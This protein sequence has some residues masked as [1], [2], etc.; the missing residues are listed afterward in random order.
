MIE[1]L[2]RRLFPFINYVVRYPIRILI[3]CVITAVIGFLL[4]INLKI[5]NDLSKLIPQ[6]YPSVQA[7]NTLREQVGAE[8][9]LAVAIESPSFEVNKKFAEML[10]SKTMALKNPE[11]ADNFF[12][13]A[14]FRRETSFL[15]NNALYF[16]TE[17]EL[18]LLEE[19]LINR[20]DEARLEANPFYFELEEKETK[21]DSLHE[22][23]EDMYD[24][25]IG[26][27]YLV[28]EDSLTL[29]IKFYPA[30]SQTDIEFIRS[31][32]STMQHL[33]DEMNPASFH[34][35][36]EVTLAGR[37]L[38][39][40][41]EVE[42]ITKDVK[43]S[44]GIGVL[45]VL[46]VAVLYFLYKSSHLSKGAE[47]SFRKL[48]HELIRTPSIVI[49]MAL[50]LVLSLC[51]TFGIVFL[52]FENLNI[53]TSTLGLVLFGMGID[54]G[55]HFFA[56][57]NEERETEGSITKA[58]ITTF[59]TSGQAIA[60]VGITTSAA[61]FVLSI[62]DFKGFSEFGI[63]A[64][65][66]IIFSIIAYVVFL[67]ALLSILEQFHLL[68]LKFAAASKPERLKITR[69]RRLANAA[70]PLIL[71]VSISLTVYSVIKI[72]ETS[73]NYNF[74]EL[75]PEFVRYQ[76]VS[77]KVDQAYSDKGTRNS[78]YIITDTPEDAEKVAA[79]LHQRIENDEVSPTVGSIEIFQDR[80]PLTKEASENKLSR[81]SDIREK[82]NDPFLQGQDNQ[83]LQR[84]KRAASTTMP[85]SLNEVP[86]FIRNPFTSKNGEIGTLV[87]IHPSVG[88][89]DGRNSINFSDDVGQ[90]ALGNGKIYYA[91]STSIVASDMLRLMINEVPLM[92]LLT[93]IIII[94]LKFLFLRG[95][96][97]TLLALL[98]LATSFIWLFGL[99]HSFGLQL[100]F[101]NLVVLPTILGIGDDS[102]IHIT[103]RYVEEGK[104]RISSVL[105][106]TGE[107]V[108]ISALTTM[109]GFG[110][111]LFSIHPGM[112]SIGKLAILG[113]L[114]TLIAALILLPAVL[115]ILEI[116]EDFTKPKSAIVSLQK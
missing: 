8:N 85:I 35:E 57:Y 24:E 86:D 72:P 51:W 90:V 34:P 12:T 29:A 87:I 112:V 15:E 55:I 44:F 101:Y 79:V 36:M 50:P 28:S 49:V 95:L 65:M 75:E 64:G 60:V 78:A 58:L 105:R 54:F 69:T 88:L 47:F 111:L 22:D 2:F 13:R 37:L 80:F 68:N 59:M 91:G 38:R 20:I 7:L 66:G 4:A 56:R 61:F 43:D 104:G 98:P 26:S 73:F 81:I 27:E 30:G 70:L 11:T 93:I 32:Y 40:L 16:A 67:P 110:G 18:D 71:I 109:V 5:D 23:L 9:E 31:V 17:K 10:I 92:V 96:K 108:T 89:S 1:H 102:G 114:F 52:L 84:L 100:N 74:G 14:E 39:M 42:T 107:H 62:A 53:M 76:T 19:Y 21:T 113:I 25:L 63:I 3:V 106:S 115:K 77:R 41:I 99:I 46:G 94:A 33:I 103:H 97:W 116:A 48:L 82:F 83:Q 6:K 45:M